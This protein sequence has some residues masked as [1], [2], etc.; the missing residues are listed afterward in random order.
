MCDIFKIRNGTPEMQYSQVRIS[1]QITNDF[2]R[3]EK[4]KKRICALLLGICILLTLA[5]CSTAGTENETEA[6]NPTSGANDAAPAEKADDT[7]KTGEP[8]TITYYTWETTEQS[9]PV[10]DEIL[11]KYNIKVDVCILPDTGGTDKESALDIVAMSGSEMDFRIITGTQAASRVQKGFAL[12]L[13][14][15]IAKYDI[16]MEDLFGKYAGESLIRFDGV[17]YGIPVRANEKMWF[18]NKTIFDEL[19]LDYPQDGWTWDEYY[20]LA[21]KITEMSDYYGTATN[22]H[23]GMWYYNGLLQGGQFFDEN[24]KFVMYEDEY[25]IDSLRQYKRMDDEGVKPSFVSMRSR[26]AYIS[27]E[28]L[29]GKCAMAEGF[30]YILRDM[31]LPDQFP[32]D[33]EVGVVTPPVNAKGDTCYSCGDVQFLAINPASE[34]ADEAFL[35]MVYYMQYGAKYMTN[36]SV[37]PLAEA[38]DSI[39]EAFVVDTPISLEDGKKFFNP[40]MQFINAQPFGAYPNG[41]EYQALMN[42]EAEVYLTGGQDL[43][44]TIANIRA[45]SMAIEASAK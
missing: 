4:M 42:E 1:I 18:Y 24:G 12:D 22:A 3:N 8:V 26:N 39:I 44:T 36:M 27:T 45:R 20:A 32:F 21:D 29:S 25:L 7:A 43:D 17:Y 33:F 10:W 6:K 28:F 5:A 41:V 34:H 38:D 23:P 13:T 14:D 19:G 16:N 30:P 11:E 31:R 9:N 35:A 37:P 2:E 15:L 40:D